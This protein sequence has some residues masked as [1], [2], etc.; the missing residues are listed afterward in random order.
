MKI[1]SISIKNPYAQLILE[2]TKK[3]EIRSQPVKNF[4]EVLVCASKSKFLLYELDFPLELYGYNDYEKDIKKLYKGSGYAIGVVRITD[5]REMLPYDEKDS[6]VKYDKKKYAW[7]L[8]D[9]RRLK[10][11]FSVAGNL[12]FFYVDVSVKQVETI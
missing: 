7:F 3:I 9:P 8:E 5:C 12:G 11:P 10:K 1:K 2:G 4:G 6:M